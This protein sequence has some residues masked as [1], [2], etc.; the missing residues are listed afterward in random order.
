MWRIDWSLRK[1]VIK[2]IYFPLFLFFPFL[3]EHKIEK[4]EEGRKNEKRTCLIEKSID[5]YKIEM[6]EI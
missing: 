1:G 2:N 4:R 3:E 6:D 5:E